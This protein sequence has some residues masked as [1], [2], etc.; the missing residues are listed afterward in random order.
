ML[1][2]R[3]ICLGKNPGSGFPCSVIVAACAPA[4][5]PGQLFLP[6][7][8]IVIACTNLN[9]RFPGNK[10]FYFA[11]QG[12][13]CSGKVLQQGLLN[14]IPEDDGLPCL[15]C[16]PARGQPKGPKHARDGT[17]ASLEILC[18]QPTKNKAGQN[19]RL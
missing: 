3:S 13:I 4:P 6:P 19:A 7:G 16:G 8:A 12:Q 18:R 15:E 11:D 10:L 5:A 2:F 17:N 1:F 9:P 14:S